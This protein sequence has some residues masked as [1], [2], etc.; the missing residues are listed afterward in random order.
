MYKNIMFIIYF[1]SFSSFG[2]VSVGT[3]NPNES[4]I[5]EL[6]SD[7]KGFLMPRMSTLQRNN[8]VSPEEG[9]LI[10]NLDRSAI[11]FYRKNVGNTSL[12]NGW[13]DVNCNKDIAEIESVLANGIVFDFTNQDEY[14]YFFS[15][16][17]GTGTKF[18]N[19]TPDNTPYKSVGPFPSDITN[20]NSTPTYVNFVNGG[21]ETTN[22]FVFQ[23]IDT[24]N[25]YNAKTFLTRLTT[26]NSAFPGQPNKMSSP[27]LTGYYGDIDIL[28]VGKFLNGGVGPNL[29]SLI[30]TGPDNIG[31]QIGLGD[32]INGGVCDWGHYNLSIGE[33]KFIC[34]GSLNRVKKD[35]DFHRFRLK[36]TAST[37]RVVF[38]IDGNIIQ[39][40]T[41]S[42]ANLQT[43]GGVFHNIYQRLKLFSSRDDSDKRQAASNI[44]FIGIY[45]THLTANDFEILD[46]YLECKFE[47]Q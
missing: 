1:I 15:E 26:I 4:S 16:T 41:L 32:I 46:K 11:Q 23:N 42:N 35:T 47:I 44:S 3:T 5:L 34:G 28:L 24:P 30:S 8:I 36:F 13:F 18:T 40:I 2:Q 6:K 38:Y 12:L 20:V 10:Y 14:G 17:N 45:T 25:D 43:N 7:N 21:G 9:L 37:R 39:A 29:S 31:I 19:M 27:N 33:K 22:N